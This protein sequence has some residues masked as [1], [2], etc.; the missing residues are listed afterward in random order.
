[1]QDAGRGCGKIEHTL[2]ELLLTDRIGDLLA[3]WTETRCRWFESDP[4]S[5]ASDA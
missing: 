5:T 2:L 1:M 3:W 4:E